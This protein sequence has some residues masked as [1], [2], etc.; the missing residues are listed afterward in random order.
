MR[1]IVIGATG[2]LGS[3][4][5]AELEGRHEVIAAG[6]SSGERVD[7]TDLGSVHALFERTGPVD[8]VAC[9]AGD[10]HFGALADMTPELYG[11]AVGSKV[12]GQVNLVLAGQEALAPGGSITLT[13]GTLGHDPIRWGSSASLANGAIDAFV[14]AAAIEL[15]RGLRVNAVAP[16]ILAESFDAYGAFM[17]GHRPVPATEAARAFSKSIEGGQTGQVYVVT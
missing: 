8:A 11:I 6:R 12:M 10:A 4:I 2:T 5:V 13:S 3:A 17:R 14:R 16:T 15:P 1:I 9:A 7:I